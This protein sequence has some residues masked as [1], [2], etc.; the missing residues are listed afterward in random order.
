MNRLAYFS[1]HIDYETWMEKD[2]HLWKVSS[3]DDIR[4]GLT[5]FTLEPYAAEVVGHLKARGV[6]CCIVSSGIDVLAS[7][8]GK[9]LGIEPDLTFANELIYTD[10]MLKGVCQVEPYREDVIVKKIS[11]EL[12][13][14]LNEFAAVGDAAPDISLFQD[15]FLKLAYNPKDYL[16]VEAAD[17][18]L[19]DLRELLRVCL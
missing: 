17:V 6:I 3:L 5:S 19:T 1:G 4:E 8:V 2:V 7:E 9:T 15:V 16:I 10:G 12:S 14:P 13:I 18:V 11:Q